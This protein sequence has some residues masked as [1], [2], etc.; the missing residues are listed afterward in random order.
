MVITGPNVK[1]FFLILQDFLGCI[2]F[3]KTSWFCNLNSFFFSLTGFQF[4]TVKC[5]IASVTDVFP[6]HLR[7]PKR[8]ELF[9]LVV[10]SLFFLLHL[11]LV[12][13]VSK[14]RFS[15]N[16]S[17]LYTTLKTF[18]FCCR[19]DSTSFSWWIITAVPG[20]VT[21]SWFYQ[22]LWLWPG[23]L[24]RKYTTIHMFIYIYLYIL[25]K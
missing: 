23:A 17:P 15:W 11:L 21:T 10:C 9:V 5:F 4:V 2:W 8:S 19:E 3:L 16:N 1:L 13:E 7:G 12:T 14:N 25:Y 20:S 22:S 24:V 18:F 6:E